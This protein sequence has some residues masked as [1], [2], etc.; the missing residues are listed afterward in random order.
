MRSVPSSGSLQVGT[1]ARGVLV[2]LRASSEPRGTQGWMLLKSP[3]GCDEHL[4]GESSPITCFSALSNPSFALAFPFPESPPAPQLQGA[5]QGVTHLRNWD[6]WA[7]TCR[8]L[9]ATRVKAVGSECTLLHPS[10]ASRSSLS[11]VVFWG[12]LPLRVSTPGRGIFLC[13]LFMTHDSLLD[14]QSRTNSSLS[15]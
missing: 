8:T 5:W 13:K 15:A 10:P 4:G 14:W 2:V 12:D 11:P 7:R 1:Q 3:R 6:P 9:V